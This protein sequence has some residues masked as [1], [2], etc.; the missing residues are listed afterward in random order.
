MGHR[1]EG[2]E[3]EGREGRGTCALF[4]DLWTYT[5]C[6][7][8]RHHRVREWG[9]EACK[10]QSTQ[11]ISTISLFVL[12]SKIFFT[13]FL[14][15]RFLFYIFP[16]RHSFRGAYSTHNTHTRTHQQ[17]KKPLIPVHSH[18]SLHTTQQ[19]TPSPSPLS[20]DVG[21]LTAPSLLLTRAILTPLPRFSSFKNHALHP[22]PILNG[23][24]Y[25]SHSLPR[26]FHY[27][28]SPLS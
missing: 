22:T 6:E 18:F 13:F 24:N 25:H 8:E 9:V 14:P 10:N 20:S 17:N 4:F 27:R 11:K 28:Q 5:S 1:A 26:I 3:K 21:S 2:G 15:A 16:F 23:T 12:G 7:Y 19:P